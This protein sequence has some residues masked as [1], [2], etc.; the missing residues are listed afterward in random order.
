MS[1]WLGLRQL[2]KRDLLLRGHPYPRPRPV[3][4]PFAETD[5]VFRTACRLA[6]IQPTKRQASKYRRGRGKAFQFR[7]DAI[8]Q[9]DAA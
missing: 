2:G 6:E 3:N 4:G 9:T 1:E 8:H 5:M 7:R